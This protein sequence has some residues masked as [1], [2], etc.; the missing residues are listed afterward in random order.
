MIN[1]IADAE[2]ALDQAGNAC[3]SPNVTD[4]TVGLCATLEQ[5]GKLLA[6]RLRELGY[7]AGTGAIS[8]R[9]SSAGSSAGNPLANCPLTDAQCRGDLLLRPA[10]LMQVPGTQAAS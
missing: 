6:L 5:D 3:L 4:K 10:L 7:R 2:L 1:M 9:V 8:Q